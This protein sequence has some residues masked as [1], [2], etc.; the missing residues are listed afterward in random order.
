MIYFY[1]EGWLWIIF[2][3]ADA[4][5]GGLSSDLAYYPDYVSVFGVV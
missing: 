4:G 2:K 3:T 5:D 1:E